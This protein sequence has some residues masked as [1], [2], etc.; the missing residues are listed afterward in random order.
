M[1]ISVS[2]LDE[3]I[4][5]QTHPIANLVPGWFFRREEVSAGA[6]QVD[7]T[8]LWN[9]RVGNTGGYDRALDGCVKQAKAIN[10]QLASRSG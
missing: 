8:D 1:K 7:G 10:V 6:W 4:V 3:H 2:K 5:R 9:R